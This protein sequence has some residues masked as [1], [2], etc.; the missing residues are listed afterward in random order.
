MCTMSEP[1]ARGGNVAWSQI[2]LGSFVKYLIADIQ[3]L[4]CTYFRNIYELQ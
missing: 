3:I 2:T 4:I 1:A